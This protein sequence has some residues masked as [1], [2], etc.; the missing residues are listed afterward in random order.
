M[1]EL[2]GR[3]S[4]G[5]KWI[6]AAGAVV[7]ISALS[8]CTAVSHISAKL[9]QGTVSFALCDD[10]KPTKIEVQVAK[11]TASY[12][13]YKTVWVATGE[14]L[15][16]SGRVVQYGVVPTGFV[17]SSGPF[18]FLPSKS[19]IDIF[20]EG[21]GDSS[22]QFVFDGSRLVRDKWLNWNGNLVSSPCGS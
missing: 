5:R 8:G 14:L 20:F 22:S 6:V 9:S 18:D 3:V 21:A 2:P 17:T 16:N 19:H 4:R 11:S 10:L 15:P 7:L 12:L 13:K 1:S